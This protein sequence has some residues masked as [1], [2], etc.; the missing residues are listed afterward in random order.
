[1][2]KFKGI[3]RI[4]KGSTAQFQGY[5]LKTV[6]ILL[7]VNKISNNFSHLFQDCFGICIILRRY[8][9]INN[10]PKKQLKFREKKIYICVDLFFVSFTN[11]KGI[12]DFYTKFQAIS[13]VQGDKINSRL[14]KGFKE[15]WEPCTSH[16]VLRFNIQFIKSPIKRR[17]CKDL[18]KHHC[19]ICSNHK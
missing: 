14:F 4:I 9:T 8:H 1:M 17:Y 18:N 2:R 10:F 5:F 12:Q 16:A 19:A 6:V 3:S 7:Y 13:R 15:P 11:F